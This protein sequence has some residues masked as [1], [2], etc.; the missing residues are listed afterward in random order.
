MS[1][2]WCDENGFTH[3]PAKPKSNPCDES[4]MNQQDSDISV[5][6]AKLAAKDAEIARLRALLLEAQVELEELGAVTVPKR[7]H[8]A[9][10]GTTDG[11]G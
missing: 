3:D 8:A 5:L 4:I 6:L 11:R 1:I 7:I 9:L 10:K 2:D